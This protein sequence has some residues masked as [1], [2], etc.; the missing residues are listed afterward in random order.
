MLRAVPRKAHGLSFFELSYPA[1][2]A[3]LN[4]EPAFSLNDIYYR[5]NQYDLMDREA[6]LQGKEV[7]YFPGIDFP[8][9]DS[10][11]TGIGTLIMSDTEYFCHFNRVHIKLPQADREFE[12][13]EKATLNLEL[14]NP[15]SKTIHFCD[16]CTHTPRLISTYFSDMDYKHTHFVKY[17]RTYNLLQIQLISLI[18]QF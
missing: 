1:L 6:E 10:L 5:K 9:C 12:I 8:G 4:Q 16:S 14:Y 13:G 7:L 18:L 3:A 15:T 11:E 2:R 17:P